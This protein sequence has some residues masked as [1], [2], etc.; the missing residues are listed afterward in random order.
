VTVRP[1]ILLLILAMAAVTYASRVGLIGVAKQVT[2]HPLLRHALEYVPVSILAALV[3]PAVLAPSGTVAPPLT[4]VYVW[5]AA[6]TV[7]VQVVGRRQWLAIVAG[8]AG[9]VL[10]RLAGFH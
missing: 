5:A 7:A 3:F 2:I 8:V 10:L 4:N 1:S 9:L 6:I